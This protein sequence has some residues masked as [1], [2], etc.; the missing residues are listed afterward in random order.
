MALFA[1]MT[2]KQLLVITIGAVAVCVVVLGLGIGYGGVR[3]SNILRDTEEVREKVRELPGLQAEIKR[4]KEK[5]EEMRVQRGEM[6][7]VLPLEGDAGEHDLRRDMTI[8][9]DEARI[10]W[11]SFERLTQALGLAQRRKLLQMPYVREDFRME[12]RGGFD[13]FATFVN[14]IEEDCERLVWVDEIDVEGAVGGLDPEEN[15]HEITIKL[16]AFK[17]RKVQA[18][19]APR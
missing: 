17:F 7:K 14:K 2:E 3:H 18:P 8:Y 9:A 4:L 16:A 10:R 12:V 5:K 6:E 13:P 1:G 11:T 15:E 19:E